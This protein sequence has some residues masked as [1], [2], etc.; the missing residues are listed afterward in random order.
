[1]ETTT[2]EKR[3]LLLAQVGSRFLSHLAA[4][5]EQNRLHIIVKLEDNF[6][7]KVCAKPL[8]TIVQQTNNGRESPRKPY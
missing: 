5:Y 8:D 2:G 1:M 3:G 6:E 7:L 4:V